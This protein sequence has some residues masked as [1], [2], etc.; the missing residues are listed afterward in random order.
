MT[1]HTA[2]YL[3]PTPIGNLEDITLRA[4]RV[5]KEVDIVLAEDNAYHGQFV[6][7]FADTPA[8][9][10]GT[11]PAQRTLGSGG[12]AEVAKTGTDHGFGK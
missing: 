1:R 7:T 5:L 10:I 3:V 6:E 9:A 11:P 4:L 2:L 8:A 12:I